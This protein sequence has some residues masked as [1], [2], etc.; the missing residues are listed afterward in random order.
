MILI[1]KKFAIA[2]G[3]VSIENMMQFPLNSFLKIPR[4]SFLPPVLGMCVL[5]WFGK[6]SNL[7]PSSV[8]HDLEMNS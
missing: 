7:G 8:A 1:L 2:F 4:S 6:I 5:P 3:L